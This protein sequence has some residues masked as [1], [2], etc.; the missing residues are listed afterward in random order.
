[1]IRRTIVQKYHVVPDGDDWKVEREDASRASF[2]AQTKKEAVARGIEI[3]RN[4]K[5]A[6]YIHG[7]DGKI[8]EERSYD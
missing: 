4:K 5:A 6:L 8:Q 7:R 2:K 1:M 3:A